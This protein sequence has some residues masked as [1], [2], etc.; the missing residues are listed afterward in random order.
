VEDSQARRL[1]EYGYHFSSASTA[2][3]TRNGVG[4]FMSAW[5]WPPLTLTKDPSSSVPYCFFARVEDFG[6]S[7]LESSYSLFRFFPPYFSFSRIPFHVLSP[8]L[9]SSCHLVCLLFVPT[10]KGYEWP[11]T[12][13]TWKRKTFSLHVLARPSTFLSGPLSIVPLCAWTRFLALSCDFLRPF[14]F[15]I[16]PAP[17]LSVLELLFTRTLSRTLI[18]TT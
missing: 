12:L 6:L 13:H 8:S 9:T 4:Q 11:S 10:Q 5:F 1:G 2:E 14:A 7:C 16:L 18:T 3:S 15:C 17:P